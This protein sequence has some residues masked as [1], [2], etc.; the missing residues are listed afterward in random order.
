MR[1]LSREDDVALR[2][3]RTV[4]LRLENELGRRGADAFAGRC[5]AQ[6][7]ARVVAVTVRIGVGGDVVE[8]GTSNARSPPRGDAAAHEVARQAV[9]RGRGR[10]PP[11]ANAE[12]TRTEPAVR[13]S[14][15][16][17]PSFGRADADFVRRRVLLGALGGRTPLRALGL[18]GN[19]RG[20]RGRRR[21][22]SR[23]R[24]TPHEP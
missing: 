22:P 15:E 14:S 9:G 2:G 20:G 8:P 16:P 5:A 17:T 10:S 1:T 4:E 7:V 23:R 11:E 18:G 21:A 6:A 24:R 12:R 19:R 3:A 13:F